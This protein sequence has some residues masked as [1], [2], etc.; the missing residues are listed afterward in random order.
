MRNFLQF[1]LLFVCLLFA[2]STLAH[3]HAGFS[4][5]DQQ[6]LYQLILLCVAAGLTYFL[7]TA[8][9]PRYAFILLLILLGFG[10]LSSCFASFPA[11]ALKE[12]ARYAG[13]LI[14]ALIIADSARK[15][16][17]FKAI[18]Y[19]LAGAALLKAF[20]ALLYYL[21]ALAIDHVL[22]FNT[23]L[24][25]Y[26]FSN[27]RFLNL[28][29]MLCMPVLAYLTLQHWQAKHRY[30]QLLAC[31]FFITL[32]VQWCIAFSLGGRGLWLGLATSH[33]ALIVFFPRF[34]RLL[35]V[36]TVSG[37]LGFTLFY[38]MFTIIPEWLDKTPVVIDSLR[39]G[40]SNREVI[41]QIAW[42]KFIAHP[43]LGIGPMHFSAE[44]NP[45]AAHPHQVILQWLAEWGIFATSVAIFMAAW[46]MSHGLR[47]VRS[48]AGEPVDAALW[49]SILG[50]LTLAQVD[51]VFVMP[52]T[53]TWLAIL[54]GLAIARWSHTQAVYKTQENCW[55]AYS[56]RLLA[57]PVILVIGNVLINEV[58]ILVQ[59][60]LARTE[61]HRT[62][63]M[64]RFWTQGWISIDN[65]LLPHAPGKDSEATP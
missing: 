59:D 39:F 17:F 62:H 53:E 11:W 8:T 54:I 6:R 3:W 40:L 46:G 2:G 23:A 27:P 38:L 25:Y 20:L 34:W 28:F 47:Y 5:H 29:Q 30:S 7:P 9:L 63:Y 37:L 41:W 32:L 49:V 42:D 36:Q 19:L 45:V 31:L 33:I 24:I 48:Q 22:M 10:L 58:P 26:G 50:A 55:Q 35:R 13:L 16:W 15:P 1:L 52:Y 18:L 44:V 51:G 43:W 57:V 60:N 64:P 65:K 61:K 56:L 14:L 21:L 12:W 4:W